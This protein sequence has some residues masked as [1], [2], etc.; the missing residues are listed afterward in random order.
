MAEGDVLSFDYLNTGARAY[1][2]FAGGIDVPAVL[3]SRSTYALGSIGG[4]DGRVLAEGDW[5]AL[6]SVKGSTAGRSVPDHLRPT[7][8]YHREIRVMMGLFDHR[9]TSTGREHVPRY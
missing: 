7:H 5:I 6:G 8:P 9:L 1:I 3:G 4:I 2:A